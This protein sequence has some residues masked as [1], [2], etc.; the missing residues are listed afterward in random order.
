MPSW[1]GSPWHEPT[2]QGGTDERPYPGHPS[3]CD[4]MAGREATPGLGDPGQCWLRG[5]LAR[6]PA[7][8]PASRTAPVHGQDDP[9]GC[10]APPWGT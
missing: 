3:R 10:C 6:V 9:L 5:L 8:G 1:D 4:G 7:G 2:G